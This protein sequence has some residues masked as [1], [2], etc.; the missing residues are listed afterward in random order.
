[1]LPILATTEYVFVG[2]LTFNPNGSKRDKFIHVQRLHHRVQSYGSQNS[3]TRLFGGSNKAVGKDSICRFMIGRE[4]LRIRQLIFVWNANL[5]GRSTYCCCSCIHWN[6]S[7]LLAIIA[8]FIDKRR[9]NMYFLPVRLYLMLSWGKISHFN[10]L[11]YRLFPMYD[12]IDPGQVLE[13]F[14]CFGYYGL[15]STF[16]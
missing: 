16:N 6:C 12:K 4:F 15:Q 14:S 10:E 7:F 8:L 5:L 2:N 1:M 13:R 11:L 9:L 3:C